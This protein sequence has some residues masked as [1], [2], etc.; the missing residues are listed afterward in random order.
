M[1]DSPAGLSG[2]NIDWKTNT[3]WRRERRRN[4]DLALNDL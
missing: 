1:S 3:T 4:T 2:S